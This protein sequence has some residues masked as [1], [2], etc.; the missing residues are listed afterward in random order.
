MLDRLK[1]YTCGD[2]NT[3][4][5]ECEIYQDQFPDDVNTSTHLVELSFN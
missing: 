2:N 1:R 3:V 5:F 4:A